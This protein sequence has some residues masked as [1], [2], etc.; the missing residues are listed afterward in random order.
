LR[1]FGRTTKMSGA[2]ISIGGG[3]RSN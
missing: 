2:S 1:S 3:E